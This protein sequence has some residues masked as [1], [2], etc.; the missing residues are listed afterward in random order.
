MR[1]RPACCFSVLPGTVWCEKHWLGQ[2]MAGL[3]W[4]LSAGFPNSPLSTPPTCSSALAQGLG[5]MVCERCCGQHR[6]EGARS[7]LQGTSLSPPALQ[8]AGPLMQTHG[9]TG[10]GGPWRAWH[11]SSRALV[12]CPGASH[13][14]TLSPRLSVCSG[15]F[16]ARPGAWGQTIELRGPPFNCLCFLSLRPCGGKFLHLCFLLGDPKPRLLD[17][18]SLQPSTLS[19]GWAGFGGGFVPRWTVRFVCVLEGCGGLESGRTTLAFLSVSEIPGF[20]A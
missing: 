3:G 18:G 16:A 19:R 10:T 20:L 6:L 4:H 7:Q 14:S 11:L 9:P 12:L 15:R 5:V 17:P 2:V 1:S 8:P 13:F